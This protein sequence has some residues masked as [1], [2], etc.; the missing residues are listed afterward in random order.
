MAPRFLPH[1]AIATIVS[2]LNSLLGAFQR[3]R[4]GDRIAQTAI[5]PP[6]VFI[7]GHWRSGTTL[8]HELL[9]SDR[10][11]AAPNTY[12]CILPNHFVL[13]ERWGAG[14]TR[15]FI[16][17]RRVMDDM[18]LAMDGPQEDEFALCNMGLDSPYLWLAFPNGRYAVEWESLETLATDARDYW[19][20]S[21]TRFLQAVS[22]VRPGR[23][24]VKNPLHSF[25]IPTLMQM[26]PGARFVHIVREPA[27]VLRSTIRTWRALHR[28]HGY[29]VFRGDGLQNHVLEVGTRMFKALLDARTQA[30][31]GHWCDVRF[32]N[33]IA[34]P[35]QT[36]ERVYVGLTLGDYRSAGPAV[37]AYLSDAGKVRPQTVSSDDDAALVNRHWD[38]YYSRYGY[39]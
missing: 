19:K 38:F 21:L 8:L 30:P 9:A 1:A 22:F 25:R 28:H 2:P 15:W 31:E 6:P 11:H 5:D 24:I 23:L 17:E 16:P 36:L 27:A 20:V 10:R 18:R 4:Y 14:L 39:H 3:L 37:D 13:T 12:Q 26:F 29:Q 33:L 7:V 34:D 35:R 32:E